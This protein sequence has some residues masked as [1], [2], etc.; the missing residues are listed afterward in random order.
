MISVIIPTYNRAEKLRL[1]IGSIAANDFRSE[2]IE[3]IVIDDQSADQTPET[4]KQL[5][6]SIPLPLIYLR[7]DHNRGPAASRNRGIQSAKGRII[8]FTDDDCIVPANWIRSYVEHLDANPAVFGIG[9]SLQPAT[10]NWIATIEK[11]K[12][13]A[14]GIRMTQ[15]V[16]GRQGIPVGFTNNLAYR[17]EVFST[18]GYF[19]EAFNVPAGEDVDFKNRVIQEHDLAF[20][21]IPVIHNHDYDIHYLVGLLFK[22]GLNRMPPKNPV[23]RSLLL[24]VLSPLLCI[25]IIRKITQ[26]HSKRH[27]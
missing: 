17:A 11:I 19:N 9:G 14:L 4:I 2:P 8:F 12:D 16:S 15:A 20:L 3:V 26:Y 6:A 7:N 27:L 25:N 21:P 24:L 13:R 1:A 5:Q 10:K 18:M 22:Q 23:L